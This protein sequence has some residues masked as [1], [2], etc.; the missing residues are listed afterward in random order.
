MIWEIDEESDN[1]ISWDEFQLTYFRNIV[2]TAQTMHVHLLL[3]RHVT[4][5]LMCL[6]FCRL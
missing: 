3:Y 4:F 2:S 6:C 5:L 1:A